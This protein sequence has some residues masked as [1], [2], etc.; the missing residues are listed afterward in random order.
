[1][2]SEDGKVMIVDEFTGR[3]L[4]GRRWSDGLHQAVEAKERVP[5]QSE[6]QTLATISFQNFFRLYDKLSGMTGTADT[7]A[8]EFHKIYELDVVVIPTN[9]PIARDDSRTS[10]YK[11]EREKFS[12]I[13]EEIEESHK[14]GQPVLVGT[15]SVEKSERVAHFSTS[16][17][18]RTT[19]S[20]PSSTSVKRTSSPR[21]AAG[22]RHRRHQHGRSRH[23]HRARRQPRDAAR[24]RCENARRVLRPEQR[25]AAVAKA[26]S[27]SSRS[28]G[29]ARREGRGGLH[30][31]GTE[32]HESRRI[33]NQLRGRS[34]RQGDPGSSRFFLSLEDDLMRIFAGERVQAMMDRL[35]MEED[36][37]DRAPM[38]HR[39]VE[40]AQKKVEERNFDIRKH[41]LEYDDVMNQQRKSMYAL[42]KQ[43]LRGEYRSVPTDEER[44]AGVE[45][46]PFVEEVDD[47]PA[48]ARDQ[49]AREHGEV[50]RVSPARRGAHARGVSRHTDSAPSSPSWPR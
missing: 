35:G 2:V 1:M 20:T 50:P 11:T 31:I 48:R 46:E 12:A 36:S 18:S 39:A 37:P 16:A 8:T 3:V 29:D 49:G 10:I 15:T 21:R 14:R 13:C 6:N 30:I 26:T 44:K 4:P 40:N 9:K 23:R 7:E 24:S 32:R 5:I 27:T 22:R 19:C 42:R 25:D 17:G 43:V 34:G 28:E 45:P 33:D 41:L 47:G 38:G